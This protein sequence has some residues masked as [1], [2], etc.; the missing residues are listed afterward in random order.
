M[1]KCYGNVLTEICSKNGGHHECP[2]YDKND[3]DCFKETSL[4]G[5]CNCEFKASCHVQRQKAQEGFREC[6]NETEKDC[7]FYKIFIKQQSNDRNE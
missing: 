5:P 2:H 6:F 3:G 7:D 4:K 1:K